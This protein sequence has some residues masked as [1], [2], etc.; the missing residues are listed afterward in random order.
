MTAALDCPKAA[1][2]KVRC[3]LVISL[4][5]SWLL[6][7]T[8]EKLGKE[9]SECEEEELASIL[10]RA[11]YCWNWQLWQINIAW[12]AAGKNFL[13]WRT[14]THQQGTWWRVKAKHILC[15]STVEFEVIIIRWQQMPSPAPGEYL[16]SATSSQ[17]VE[18]PSGNTSAMLTCHTLYSLE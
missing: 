3:G 9:P 13:C 10:V 17:G 11:M 12:V 2:C 4:T 5:Y 15:P 7:P 6:Q 18:S 1:Q 14:G 16:L 8:R